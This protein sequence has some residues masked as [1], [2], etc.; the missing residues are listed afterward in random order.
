MAIVKPHV[1]L[2]SALANAVP[3]DSDFKVGTY[4]SKVIKG[5]KTLAKTS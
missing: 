2:L 5:M 1:V 3:N 4:K